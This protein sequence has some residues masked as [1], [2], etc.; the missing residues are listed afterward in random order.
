MAV[1]YAPA[2]QASADD[3]AIDLRTYP[4]DRLATPEGQ[5]LLASARDHLE[6]SGC[7]VLRS[8]I[9]P[10]VL[11]QMTAE[12]G[13]L[14]PQAFMNHTRTNAYSSDP[15]PS[16][17]DDHPRNIFLTRTNGFVG[18]DLIAEDT[19][20]KR[21]YHDPGLQRFIAELTG[22]EQIYP[23][24]DPLAGLVLNVIPDG[25]QHPWHFDNNDFIVSLMTQKPVQ[26]GTFEYCPQLRTD[27][28]QNY[29][30][31]GRVIGGD[32][33]LVHRLDIQ[34]GDLQLFYGRNSLHRVSPV[35]GPRARHT[36]I[37]AYSDRP[38]V[39]GGVARTRRLFGRVT[40]AHHAAEAARLAV[41]A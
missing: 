20:L 5:A 11:A 32:R 17:P 35:Q 39:I 6:A 37:L 15:D 30:A 38:G 10:D 25:C 14:A 4:V 21:L 2:E 7:V 18:G 19:W 8:F 40:Q 33:D 3:S 22:M 9:R 29:D 16:L 28:A 41:D 1:D 31:V 27:K 34:P 12:G 24:A 23:Y 13:R 26:G 36:L